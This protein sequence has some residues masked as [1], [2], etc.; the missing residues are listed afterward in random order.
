VNNLGLFESGPAVLI[1]IVVK[2][3][4]FPESPFFIKKD[5]I[6]SATPSILK[7][8][9]LAEAGLL[10]YDKVVRQEIAIDS[11]RNCGQPDQDS[12]FITVLLQ[13]LDSN[14][15]SLV[16]CSRRNIAALFMQHLEKRLY[17]ESFANTIELQDVSPEDIAAKYIAYDSAVHQAAFRSLA[18]AEKAYDQPTVSTKDILYRLRETHPNSRCYTLS[19][20]FFCIALAIENSLA[21]EKKRVVDFLLAIVSGTLF[22]C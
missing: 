6:A 16:L 21:R 8:A 13:I 18:A 14:K 15:Q 2:F 19:K 4:H 1:H 10:T 9:F 7:S 22:V 20:Q 11:I 5:G 17:V 12:L 3:A